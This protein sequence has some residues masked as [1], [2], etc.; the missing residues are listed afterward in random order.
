[1]A[2][3]LE[4]RKS[5]PE[6]PILSQYDAMPIHCFRRS[7][8]RPVLED[9]NN[10]ILEY[11]LLRT[12]PG[13]GQVD[14][15]SL[16]IPAGR[17]ECRRKVNSCLRVLR[18]GRRRL[19]N[20]TASSARLSSRHARPRRKAASKSSKYRK[21]LSAEDSSPRQAGN[22]GQRQRMSRRPLFCRAES[23]VAPFYYEATGGAGGNQAFDE[24]NL[25]LF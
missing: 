8:L 14:Q 21:A 15:R 2:E 23:P 13:R 1:V 19:R 5:L 24:G 12:V 7:I 20:S 6:V 22:V 18:Q 9:R 11:Y 17:S 3:A 4:F 25:A 10:M 16:F